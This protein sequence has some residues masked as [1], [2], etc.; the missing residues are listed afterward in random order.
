MPDRTTN[1]SEPLI[2]P[3]VA[4]TLVMAGIVGAGVIGYRQ[5]P[6]SD[7]PTVDYPTINVQAA[8]A[9]ASPETMASVVATPLEKRFS[10]IPGVDA[11]TSTSSQGSTNI[12]LQFSLDRSIDAAAQDVQ[13][14]IAGVSPA[15]PRSMLPPAYSKSSPTHFPI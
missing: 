13:S 6:V 1:I 12:T 11:I 7:L 10:S 4:T 14:A 2:R 3:P 9:G 15:L 5:L 8:L